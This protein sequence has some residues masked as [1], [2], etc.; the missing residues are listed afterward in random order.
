MTYEII[1]FH[2]HPFPDTAA[3]IN[4]YKDEETVD[5]LTYLRGLGISGI[6]GSVIYRLAPGGDPWKA[7][8][9]SNNGALALR[10]KFGSFYIPGFHV[11][12]NYVKESCEEIERM[13]NA[14][15]H[16][17]GELVPYLHGWEDYSCSAFDEI[18]DTASQY[19]MIVSFHSMDNDQMDTMVRRHPKT[20]FVAAHPG[21]Y[22]DY[23]R[24]L[25]RMKYS[26][27]YYLDL[28]GY[29]LF[30][31]RMLRHGIDTVGLHRFIFGSDYPTCSPAMYIGGVALDTLLTESEKQQIFS[32]NAKRLLGLE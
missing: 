8:L 16:L 17:I 5:T 18:L 15:I 30:R 12:P 3:N 9:D 6:C 19:N 13:H 11:H 31:H 25:E 27:N 4:S 20:V 28:S 24:H 21:E 32:G 14:G 22:P 26:E 7:V 29:G 2:T 10:E 1:D 23:M